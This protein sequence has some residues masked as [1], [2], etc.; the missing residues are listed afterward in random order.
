[1]QTPAID[2]PIPYERQKHGDEGFHLIILYKTKHILITHAAITIKM[3]VAKGVKNAN[4]CHTWR[5]RATTYRMSAAKN[6]A[7]R[8][9]SKKEK[10][11]S[12]HGLNLAPSPC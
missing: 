6:I 9:V 12:H 10:R 7:H 3:S 11:V 8:N 4:E 2:K 1:M 5:S